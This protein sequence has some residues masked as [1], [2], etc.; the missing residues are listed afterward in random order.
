M[1]LKKF[2]TYRIGWSDL[3]LYYYGVRT[4]NKWP[5]EDDLWKYYYTSSPGVKVLRESYGE[6]DIIEVRKRFSNRRRA[7]YWESEVIRR[8]VYH[9]PR[10]ING[11]S[12]E[13]FENV[14]K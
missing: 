14:A 6:P 8:A 4:A 7:Q 9:N 3:D 1:K 5:P 13:L 2:Y 11:Q 10:Y 12:P